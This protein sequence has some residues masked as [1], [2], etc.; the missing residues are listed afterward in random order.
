V[1]DLDAEL[2]VSVQNLKNPLSFWDKSVSV[3]KNSVDIECKSHILCGGGCYVRHIL[4][5]GGEDVPGWLDGG[6]P[7]SVWSAI[8][9][10]GR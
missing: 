4:H 9:I 7:W 6:H 8:C 3:H 2:V 1:R 5:L 10:V